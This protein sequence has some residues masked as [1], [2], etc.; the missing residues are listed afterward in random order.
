MLLIREY[1]H[2]LVQLYYPHVCNGCGSDLLSKD[3]LLCMQC[4]N[5]LP[6][7]QFA[8]F[9]DNFIEKIFHGRMAVEAAHSEFF[10]SKGKMLQHLIHQL[11]YNANTS[12]GQ[13]L[14]SIMGLT[15]KQSNRFEGLQGLVAMPLY[16]DK[17][18]L[19]GYNQAEVICDG[20]AETTGI[21]VIRKNIVRLRATETQTRKHRAERW[22]NVSGSFAVSDPDAIKGKHLL[23]VD[24]VITTGASIEA[25]GH[26]ILQVPGTLLSIAALAHAS[27]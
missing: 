9:K 2:N 18:K 5:S 8:F 1:L 24:D 20:I 13:Y 16:A 21:P 22:Q 26:A 19:R 3:Q 17:E 15:L 6:H 23:L 27:K 11:K 14:G 12:I 4:R 25:C 7:T 10:F